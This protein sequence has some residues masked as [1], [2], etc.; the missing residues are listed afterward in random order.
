VQSHLIDGVPVERLR[1]PEACINTSRCP[2]RGGT[3]Q[4]GGL[5]A[6]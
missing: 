5:T 1:L 4:L 3:V 6:S 2:H